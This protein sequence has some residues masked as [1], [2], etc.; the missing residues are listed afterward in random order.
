MKTLDSG[1]ALAQESRWLWEQAPS[2]GGALTLLGLV[3]HHNLRAPFRDLSI[4]GSIRVP[5]E[6]VLAFQIDKPVEIVES[7]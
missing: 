4:F 1:T 5:A 6:G 2:P 3:A 7:T